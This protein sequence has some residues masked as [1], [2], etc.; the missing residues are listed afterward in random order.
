MARKNL[1]DQI[2]E[3]RESVIESKK[4][5]YMV[6]EV[7]D[8][9]RNPLSAG[10]VTTRSL[11]VQTS[12]MVKLNHVA[13]PLSLAYAMQSQFHCSCINASPCGAIKAKQFAFI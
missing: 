3:K 12:S 13:I 10:P 4:A 8:Q 1:I 5:N 6:V 2:V 9:S 7:G 11:L